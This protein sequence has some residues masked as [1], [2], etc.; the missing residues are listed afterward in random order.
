MRISNPSLL[1]VAGVVLGLLVTLPVRPATGRSGSFDA[2]KVPTPGVPP[3]PWDDTDLRPVD[4][5]V[6]LQ[7]LFRDIQSAR[8]L[9]PRPDQLIRAGFLFIRDYGHNYQDE[10]P[11]VL[12]LLAWANQNLALSAGSNLRQTYY[13]AATDLLRDYLDEGSVRH[14]QHAERTLDRLEAEGNPSI[15]L[16]VVDG[17]AVACEYITGDNLKDAL[18]KLDDRAKHVE[19]GWNATGFRAGYVLLFGDGKKEHVFGIADGPSEK[20]SFSLTPDGLIT[21]RGADGERSGQIPPEYWTGG[22]VQ[23]QVWFASDTLWVDVN[24]LVFN[25]KMLDEPSGRALHEWVIEVPKSA[26]LAGFELRPWDG[27]T[28]SP[29]EAG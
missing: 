2:D 8:G 21:F 25:L 19:G 13:K 14:R 3:D 23:V 11:E 10:S 22:R 16:V 29:P 7:G 5:P 4:L 9:Q 1:L 27:R 20:F 26:T 6:G 18:E 15:A 28:P 24:N 17:D 12:L